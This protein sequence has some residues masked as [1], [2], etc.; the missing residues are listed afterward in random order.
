MPNTYHM[1]NLNS[2]LHTLNPHPFFLSFKNIKYYSNGTIYFDYYFVCNYWSKYNQ[3]K[4]CMAPKRAAR[5]ASLLSLEQKHRTPFPKNS[6]AF[7]K[8]D[9]LNACW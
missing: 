6:K 2:R 3:R 5:S 8:G 1:M 7:C 9:F 4:R